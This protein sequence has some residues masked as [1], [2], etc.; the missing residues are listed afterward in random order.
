MLNQIPQIDILN[1]WPPTP[2]PFPVLQF[3]CSWWALIM[4][5]YW[6]KSTEQLMHFKTSCFNIYTLKWLILFFWKTYYSIVIGGIEEHQKR[7]FKSS[8]Q[9]WEGL[10][11]KTHSRNLS[12][13]LTSWHCLW[14]R[15]LFLLFFQYH[16]TFRFLIDINFFVFLK[17][18]K[19]VWR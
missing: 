15:P 11:L 19:A 5:P 16:F 14:G 1:N 13:F 17:G 6:S 4:A 18:Q 12:F 3:S 10:N 2:V 8:W 9:T 7:C